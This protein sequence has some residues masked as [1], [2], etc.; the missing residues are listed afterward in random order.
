MYTEQLKF[1]NKYRI[2]SVR[3]QECDYSLPGLYFVTI[4][5]KDRQCYFGKIKDGVMELLHI[6][7]IAEKY[8][9]ELPQQFAH[10]ELGEFVIMPNHIHGI[11]SIGE[12]YTRD[13]MNR[14][15]TTT[16]VV[17][18]KKGGSTGGYN[19]MGKGTLGEI[20]RWFKGRT[21]F[22]TNR[23]KSLPYFSWQAR[24]HDHIIRTEKSLEIIRDYIRK[25][26]ETWLED[27][28]YNA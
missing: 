24:F 4:C 16:N 28:L 11:V 18:Q 6:G 19:P 13:A 10:V 25:N 22:E 1:K 14:V 15:S 3:L 27:E 5:T 9:L 7:K 12:I 23:I 20:I 26:P 21:T 8:W 2:P 17:S